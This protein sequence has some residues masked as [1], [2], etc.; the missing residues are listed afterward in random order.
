VGVIV[1]NP[2]WSLMTPQAKIT[3]T[4]LALAAEIEREFC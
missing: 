1:T 4:I 3:T 2:G